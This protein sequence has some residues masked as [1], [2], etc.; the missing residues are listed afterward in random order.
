MRQNRE[1]AGFRANNFSPIFHIFHSRRWSPIF[2]E[3]FDVSEFMAI[4]AY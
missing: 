3:T 2:A 1:G 4:L